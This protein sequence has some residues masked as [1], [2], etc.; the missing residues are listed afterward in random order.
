MKIQFLP[1][2]VVESNLYFDYVGCRI[3]WSE[4]VVEDLEI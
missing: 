3:C 4:I 2:V 1:Q